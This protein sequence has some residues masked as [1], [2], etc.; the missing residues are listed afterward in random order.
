MAD[1]LPSLLESS[2][3]SLM[4]YVGVDGE[5]LGNVELRDGKDVSVSYMLSESWTT[6]H[7][8][9]LEARKDG[10]RWA[11]TARW[12][13]FAVRFRKSVTYLAHEI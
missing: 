13:F 1:E 11:R 6:A 5:E 10:H 2:M 7:T 8:S 9:K 12:Q 3:I 4:F